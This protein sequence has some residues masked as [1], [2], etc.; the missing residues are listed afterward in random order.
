MHKCTCC[1][2]QFGF[3]LFAFYYFFKGL[4]PLRKQ[5]NSNNFV[6]IW[7]KEYFSK[8]FICIKDIMTNAPH[9]NI[10]DNDY[11]HHKLS[12]FSH[13]LQNDIRNHTMI[14]MYIVNILINIALTRFPGWKWGL[15]FLILRAI[16]WYY[17]TENPLILK[18]HVVNAVCQNSFLT[19]W[20]DWF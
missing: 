11:I 14:Y 4:R 1:S 12:W 7:W 2:V 15:I 6:K 20:S 9:A 18:V 5:E 19:L 13:H 10:N 8:C 16:I 3:A 17:I